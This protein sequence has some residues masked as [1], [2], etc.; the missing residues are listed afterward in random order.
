MAA[1]VV[2]ERLEI[3][4]AFEDPGISGTAL[5]QDRPGLSQAL[6]AALSEGAG[7]LV[8]ARHDRLPRDTLVAL[9]IERSFADAGVRILYADSSNGETDADADRFRRIVLHAAAEQAK[10]DVVR[11]LAAGREVKARSRPGSYLGGR[12][13]V[14]YKAVGHELV[15]HPDEAKLVGLI[16]DLARRG[17][18]VRTIAAELDRHDVDRRCYPNS[19][20]RVLACEI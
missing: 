6:V 8:V 3:V 19:V 11:R 18:S 20:Q 1:F 2:R 9:L 7:S 10:R 4:G 12:P 17:H 15:P 5:L 16:F 14:G 13:P